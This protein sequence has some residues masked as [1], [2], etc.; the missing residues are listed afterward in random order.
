MSPMT[1]IPSQLP[2]PAFT[3]EITPAAVSAWV[4]LPSEQRPRLIDCREADELAICQIRGNEWFPL[5][6][7]PVA[8][9]KLTADRERGIVVY[10]HHGMRSLRAAAFLRAQGVENAFSMSGGIDLWSRLID[11]EVPRY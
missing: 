9:A 1:P 6:T 11:P 2:D 7:F 3:L 4:D 8:G 10:C 5:G